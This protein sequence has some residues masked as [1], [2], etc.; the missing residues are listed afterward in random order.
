MEELRSVCSCLPDGVLLQRDDLQYTWTPKIR[1]RSSCY[2]TQ[3]ANLAL[4]CQCSYFGFYKGAGGLSSTTFISEVRA[5]NN[6][7]F[8]NCVQILASLPWGIPHLPSHRYDQKE[9]AT[10]LSFY[11][12]QGAVLK[13][14]WSAQLS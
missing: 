6:L 9:I 4:P 14:V 10:L 7:L 1:L 13:D 3:M 8:D 5:L 11:T 12:V 2:S